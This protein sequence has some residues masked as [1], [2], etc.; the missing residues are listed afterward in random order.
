MGAGAGQE[1]EQGRSRAGAFFLFFTN[2]RPPCK[3]SL[4]LQKCFLKCL[5][6]LFSLCEFV[7][8]SNDQ[9]WRIEP[10]ITL[11]ESYRA[12]CVLTRTHGDKIV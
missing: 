7:E 5:F 8:F 10:R 1:Q 3:I 2:I 11:G 12:L 6:N 9:L 4:E